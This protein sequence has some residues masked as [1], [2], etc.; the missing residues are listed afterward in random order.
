MF[1]NQSAP[2]GGPS[3]RSRQM[4]QGMGSRYHPR[5][6]EAADVAAPLRVQ[7]LAGGGAARAAL[8]HP[9]TSTA[10]SENR[11]C[12]FACCTVWGLSDSPQK[13]FAPCT[14]C[15]EVQPPAGSK[16][17]RFAHQSLDKAVKPIGALELL[18]AS[19][20]V[21]STRFLL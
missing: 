19:K 20:K 7:A 1:T 12:P 21:S 17:L 8:K 3:S 6:T 14:L 13:S 11:A 10:F 15:N 4:S 9:N 2:K 16:V 18:R 5:G